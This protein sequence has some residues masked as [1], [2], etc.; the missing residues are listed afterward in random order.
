MNCAGSSVNNTHVVGHP[1]VVRNNSAVMCLRCFA[2]YY[3]RPVIEPN[4]GPRT[5]I[6]P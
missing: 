3:G 6:R 5:V 4:H 2:Y 1:Y